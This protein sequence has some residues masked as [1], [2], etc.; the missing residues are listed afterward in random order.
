MAHIKVWL[1]IIEIMVKIFTLS[2][3]LLFE[4]HRSVPLVWH[5]STKFTIWGL[6]H[7][8]LDI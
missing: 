7:N 8:A 4:I 6:F 1:I 5:S 2:N 3:N